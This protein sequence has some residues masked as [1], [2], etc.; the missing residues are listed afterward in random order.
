MESV[1]EIQG[2]EPKPGRRFAVADSRY[3]VPDVVVQKVGSDYVV[4]LNEEDPAPTRE[5]PVS[6]SVPPLGGQGAGIRGA[7]DPLGACG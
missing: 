4:V 1:E 2:L 5:R 7:E 3:I 6:V